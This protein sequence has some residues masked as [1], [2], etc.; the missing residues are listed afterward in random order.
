[1]I[2]KQSSARVS[3]LEKGWVQNVKLKKIQDGIV[4]FG[5]TWG[6]YLHPYIEPKSQLAPKSDKV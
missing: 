3:F 2:V 1:M 6:R 4:R 5:A